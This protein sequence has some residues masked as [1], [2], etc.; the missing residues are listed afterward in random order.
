MQQSFDASVPAEMAHV[1]VLLAEVLAALRPQDGD[2]IADLTYGGGG[3]SKAIL[4]AANCSVYAFDRDPDA[5][6]NGQNT[7]AESHGRLALIEAPFS[8]FAEEL[9]ARK[10]ELIDGVVMDIGV[11]SM[12]LDQAERGFSFTKDGPLDMRMGQAGLSAADVVGRFSAERLADIIY[13][14]GDEPKSRA[15]G[16]A[17]VKARTEAPIET[18]RQLVSAIERATGPHRPHLRTHPATK[19]FQALRIFVNDELGQLA[20]AL[21]AAEAML[22]PGGRLVIVTFHSLEDRIAKQFLTERSGNLPSASRYAPGPLAERAPSFTTQ[23]KGHVSAGEEELSQNPRARS[24]KLRA[25]IRTS[26]DAWGKQ[27]ASMK[28]VAALRAN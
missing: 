1:P 6:Q 15:I 7:V 23:F 13:V 20:D 2:V 9:R 17:I 8:D 14:F 12:Q 5:I 4:A 26:A 19:T 22:K 16:R 25:A 27:S 11:S 18:T 3:Y 28:S 24:A 21:V 10:I